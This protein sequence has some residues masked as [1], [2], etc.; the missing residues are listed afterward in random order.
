MAINKK[1]SKSNNKTKTTWS[2][3]K[4]LGKQQYT[5]GITEIITERNRLTTQQ[6]IANAFNIYLSTIID[7]TNMDSQRNISYGNHHN[8]C[9][10]DQDV[11]ASYPP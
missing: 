9:Y 1:I 10:L 11:V 3:V 6:N 5:Q 7:K 2:I 4:L 8:Y